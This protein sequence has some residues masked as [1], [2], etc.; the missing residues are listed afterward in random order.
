MIPVH[1][2]KMEFL[3]VSLE[4]LFNMDIYVCRADPGIFYRYT[5]STSKIALQM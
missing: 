1:Y 5:Y 3:D 2:V 4:R